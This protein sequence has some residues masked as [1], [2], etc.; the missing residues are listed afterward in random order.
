MI[1]LETARL[2]L[3]HFSLDD[4]GVILRLLNE[5]SF[6][7]NVEDKGIRTLDQARAY[8]RDGPMASYTKHRFGL[9]R[10]ELKESGVVIGMCGLLKR[11]SLDDAEVGYAFLPEF[12]G[13]G[14]AM[15]SA[16]AVVADG[17]RTFGLTRLLAVTNAGNDASIR[18]LEKIGFSFKKMLKLFA[19]EPEIKLFAYDFDVHNPAA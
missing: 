7:E 10:V 6:I 5:P 16:S 19:N 13:N 2:R 12:F 14:Y 3:R 9:N 4:A 8:L 15:E 18:V 17:R 1:V 11:D